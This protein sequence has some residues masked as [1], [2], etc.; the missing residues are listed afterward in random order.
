MGAW[1]VINAGSAFARDPAIKRLDFF[2]V[3]IFLR[4]VRFETVCH[5]LI[6]LGQLTANSS[7]NLARW[8]AV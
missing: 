6:P 1:V 5:S 8:A 3:R 7:P 4:A 2:D